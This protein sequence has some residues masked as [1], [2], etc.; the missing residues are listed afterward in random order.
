[1]SSF[2]QSIRNYFK[3]KY[4]GRYFSVLL[5]EL[6]QNEP[7]SF[8]SIIDHIAESSQLSIWKQIS[9]EIHDR[10]LE[11]V[12][13]HKFQGRTQRRRADLTFLRG[14][15]PALLMEVKE[16]DHLN[17]E[18]PEQLSDYLRQVSAEQCFVYIYRFLPQPE[19][20]QKIAHEQQRKRPVGF[21]SYDKIYSALK[22]LTNQNRPLATLVRSYL[23]DIGVGV[24]PDIDLKH[25][26]RTAAMFVLVQ[27]LGLSQYNRMGR[28]QGDQSVRAGPDLI[29]ALLGNIEVVGEW[30]KAANTKSIT[31]RFTRRLWINPH[32]NHKKLRRALGASGNTTDELPDGIW[33]YVEGGTVS[34]VSTGSIGTK[35]KK[36]K[37]R[38]SGPRPSNRRSLYIE[39]GLRL[40]LKKEDRAVGVSVYAEI[41]SFDFGKKWELPYGETYCELRLPS[42]P[43][44]DAALRAFQRVLKRSK[45]KADKNAKPPVRAFLGKFNIPR[46]DPG[47]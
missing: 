37:G 20:C 38:V 34:F 10:T 25:K 47:P 14:E 18:N 3:T 24:Y 36:G 44:Q 29:K 19:I 39:V 8:S 21:I 1:M 6:A 13:E 23:E 7:N 28:L 22:T 2:F 45:K 46:T 40:E 30:I 43:K 17:P 4:D 35:K 12:C 32:F 41:H 26:D 27:M 16:F 33:P 9:R 42:F 11:P 31:N 5:R 15:K